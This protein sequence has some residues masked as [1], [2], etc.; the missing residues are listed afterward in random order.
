VVATSDEKRLRPTR[1]SATADGMLVKWLPSGGL[2]DLEIA[3]VRA[4]QDLRGAIKLEGEPITGQDERVGLVMRSLPRYNLC[5]LNREE[6]CELLRQLLQVTELRSRFCFVRF[7][8]VL[9]IFNPS[10]EFVPTNRLLSSV[11]CCSGAAWYLSSGPE[12]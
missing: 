4:V 6:T 12:A 2:A 3:A 5:W 10:L 1:G 7:W 8:Y 11:A 9:F